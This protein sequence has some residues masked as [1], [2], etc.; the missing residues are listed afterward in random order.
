MGNAY[1]QQLIYIL[2]SDFCQYRQTRKSVPGTKAFTIVSS[3]RQRPDAPSRARRFCRRRYYIVPFCSRACSK[4][5]LLYFSSITSAFTK[6]AM[7]MPGA[8]HLNRDA[9][10]S[11]QGGRRVV[12]QSL[13]PSCASRFVDASPRHLGWPAAF[14]HYYCY[15][16][17]HLYHAYTI[18]AGRRFLARARVYVIKRQNR[19]R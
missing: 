13:S 5:R 19:V 12:R 17:R 9:H 10:L 6:Q 4:Q 7:A 11:R 14:T 8:T 2:Y 1:G 15:Y 16:R 18:T 3:H